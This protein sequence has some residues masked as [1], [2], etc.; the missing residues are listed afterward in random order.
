MMVMIIIIIIVII[1]IIIIK[2]NSNNN[3][4]DDCDEGDK[5]LPL[6]TLL[7]LHIV[8]NVAVYLTSPPPPPKPLSTLP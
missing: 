2:N 6:N 7:W 5:T 3:N 4:G 1:T 8:S